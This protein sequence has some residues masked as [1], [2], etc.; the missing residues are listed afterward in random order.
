MASQTD[1]ISDA[2]NELLNDGF[3]YEQ[4]IF[5]L[6]ISNENDTKQSTNGNTAL[7]SEVIKLMKSGF[8]VEEAEQSL[9]I[10]MNKCDIDLRIHQEIFNDVD[11]LDII[12][13]LMDNGFEFQESCI[14]IV[15]AKYDVAQC[16]RHLV[17]GIKI[18]TNSLQSSI[19]TLDSVVQVLIN[20]GNTK[21]HAV[22]VATAHW[23]RF[24]HDQLLESGKNRLMQGFIEQGFDKQKAM[25]F[26]N[27]MISRLLSQNGHNQ[28]E[29]MKALE[30]SNGDIA[31]AQDLLSQSKRKIDKKPNELPILMAMGF[32]KAASLKA[33][34]MSNFNLNDAVQLLLKNENSA[35]FE[36][37]CNGRIGIMSECNKL[38]SLKKALQTY[39]N[40]D[41]FSNDNII[42]ALNCFHHLLKKHNSP[43]EFEAIYN[44]LDN[45]CNVLKCDKMRRI[46]RDRTRKGDEKE[47]KQS[48][49]RWTNDIMNK[50]HCHFQH[51]YD[52]GYRISK[53]ERKRIEQQVIDSD[54]KYDENMFDIS[55]LDHTLLIMRQIVSSKQN[56]PSVSRHKVYNDIFINGQ[57]YVYWDY[58]HPKS[59]VSNLVDEMNKNKYIFPKFQSLKQELTQN[60]K[61]S[62]TKEQFDN[63]Y[64]KAF[65]YKCS[66]WGKKL[67]ADPVNINQF[68]RRGKGSNPMTKG[69]ALIGIEKGREISIEHVLAVVVYCNYTERTTE[70]RN[71]YRRQDRDDYS[72]LNYSRKYMKEK[73]MLRAGTRYEEI[74]DEEK[75]NRESNWSIKGRHGNF[76]HLARNLNELIHVYCPREKDAEHAI[77]SV[78]HG[79][80]KKMRFSGVKESMHQPLSTT[81]S[82]AVA[83]NFSGNDGMV[84]EL[85]CDEWAR[86]FQ[87]EFV[88]D[89][90]AEKEIL[91][92][93]TI[94]A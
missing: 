21:E 71:T 58:F 94:G 92:I 3:T 82:Y 69:F 42:D 88:S 17:H 38:I 10:S 30:M 75:T 15:K 2:I 18:H 28:E 37:C 43:D 49:D 73:I 70:F 31:K 26:T 80:S 87:C 39:E 91:F 52:I 66:V 6:Q 23:E 89:F 57:T 85:T 47:S 50:I 40:Y 8:S 12:T 29:A 16:L 1:A 20:Y 72:D 11:M 61:C 7:I 77:S 44:I 55:P 59:T 36:E 46:R 83:I 64:R 67:V 14:A 63:E 74:R 65:Q 53:N 84:L 56:K 13:C 93:N 79:V 19:P 35:I 32:N 90:S 51:S 45:Q 68:S 41:S 76:Y 9:A 22:T 81:M 86:Y 62:L 54:V 27:V 4:A 5:A 34:E 24:N 25:H 78:Y 60:T 33:L 48:C